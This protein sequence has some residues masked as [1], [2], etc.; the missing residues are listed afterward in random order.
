MN[1]KNILEIL[2]K[3]IN[4]AND[5]IIKEELVLWKNRIEFPYTIINS[6]LLNEKGHTDCFFMKNSIVSENK[7]KVGSSMYSYLQLKKVALV[8]KYVELLLKKIGIENCDE[9]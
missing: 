4:R 3:N 7:I 8:R 1:R 2:D 6:Y 5:A 9:V